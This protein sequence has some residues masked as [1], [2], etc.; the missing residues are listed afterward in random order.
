MS[1]VAKF[2]IPSEE[3]ASEAHT[4]AIYALQIR[5]KYMVTGS[6]DTTIRR[7]DLDTGRL[8]PPIIRGPEKSIVCL[9]FDQRPEHDVLIAGGVDG[10]LRIC[11]FSTGEEIGTVA[12]AHEETL[13]SLSF[14]D[15]YIVT[16]GR[17]QKVCVWNRREIRDV[18]SLPQS[19]QH[20]AGEDGIIKPFSKLAEYAVNNA[21]INAVQLAGDS[22]I[23]GSGDRTV[24]IL[25]LN[26]G[27]VVK[28]LNTAAGVA[29]MHLN[30]RLLIAACSDG[31]VTV[32]DMTDDTVKTRIEGPRTVAR[33]VDAVS[34]GQG[35]LARVAIGK[36]DGTVQIYKK[37]STSDAWLIM[38][39]LEYGV[40]PERI[41][42]DNP[43]VHSYAEA[44][45]VFDVAFR[46]DQVYCCG[47]GNFVVGWTLPGDT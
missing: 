45:R 11:N 5:G 10:V 43:Y 23:V 34:D 44:E 40:Q 31:S 26:T 38:N 24:H 7:W 35:N 25:S 15:G 20:V 30:G 27:A 4:A 9:Q 28:K 32:W 14:D 36:Y 41:S 39:T 37:D 22:I 6:A 2:Q 18:S 13:L 17:N 46:G 29:D 19:F 12:S 8:I 1:S 3:H 33:A 16:G 21:A 42:D 47:Q